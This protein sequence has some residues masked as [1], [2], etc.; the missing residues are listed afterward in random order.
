[1]SVSIIIVESQDTPHHMIFTVPEG[2]NV[3][4]AVETVDKMV[5]ELYADW[6][7]DSN[8]ESGDPLSNMIETLAEQGIELADLYTVENK[9]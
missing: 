8:I 5:G 4:Q 1:M 6:D 3:E 7:I 9:F 2:M